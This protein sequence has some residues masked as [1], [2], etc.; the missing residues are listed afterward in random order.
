MASSG[1]VECEAATSGPILIQE[2]VEFMF[3]EA[4]WPRRTLRRIYADLPHEDQ[5]ILEG[6]PVPDGTPDSIVACHLAIAAE[7][8]PRVRALIEHVGG[9]WP[10]ELIDATDRYLRTSVGVGFELEDD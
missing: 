2:P 4:A 3:L 7:F 9:R 1:R 6:L 5:R 8:L 10:A